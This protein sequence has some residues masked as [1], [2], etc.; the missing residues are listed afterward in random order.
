MF[1]KHIFV[2]F[3]DCSLATELSDKGICVGTWGDFVRY[4]FVDEQW[5]FGSTYVED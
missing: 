1:A 4:S 5:G 2:I 3:N